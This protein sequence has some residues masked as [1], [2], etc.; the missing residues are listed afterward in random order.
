MNYSS[1]VT[2]NIRNRQS[3]PEAVMTKTSLSLPQ[4]ASY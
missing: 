1:K 4:F 3:H 2:D